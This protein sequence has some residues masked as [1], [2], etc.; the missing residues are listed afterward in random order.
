M[1][2][3]SP[4]GQRLCTLV[5]PWWCC[6]VLCGCV[7]QCASGSPDTTQM[8]LEEGRVELCLRQARLLFNFL[9]TFH[10]CFLDSFFHCPSPA[11]TI[12]RGIF[13]VVWINFAYF[14]VTFASVHEPQSVASDFFLLLLSIVRIKRPW[15]CVHHPCDEHVRTISGGAD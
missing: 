11:G 15:G 14:E 12:P 9:V 4:E 13:P 7:G 6:N 3:E 1:A 10:V 2:G 5:N 8:K